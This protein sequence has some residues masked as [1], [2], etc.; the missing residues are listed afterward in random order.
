M[1]LF[2]L[3]WGYFSS[4]MATR[5]L[6]QIFLASAAPVKEENLL[7]CQDIW[8]ALLIC[9][10]PYFIFPTPFLTG[11]GQAALQN[12]AT[13]ED[14]GASYNSEKFQQYIAEGNLD[15]VKFLS[16][17]ELIGKMNNLDAVMEREIDDLRQRYHTKRQPILDAKDQKRKSQQNF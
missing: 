14:S 3:F 6:L 7:E 9:N 13:E 17:N 8:S 4:E 10:S 5:T 11:T 12:V 15:F 2:A 1:A 16:Y